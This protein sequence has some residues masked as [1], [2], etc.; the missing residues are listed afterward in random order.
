MTSPPIRRA[1]EE[2]HLASTFPG[3]LELP[4]RRPGLRRRRL[5]RRRQQRRRQR[6]L[7]LRQRR[8]NLTIYSS[9]PLQ[10][11]SRPQSEA[12]VNGEKLALEAGRRQ[13]RRLHDQVRV[14]RRRHGCGRQVGRRRRL[15]QRAQG[16]AGQ[17]DDRLPRRVQL[18]R[19]GDLDPDPNE[20]GILQVSPVEHRA[21]PDQERRGRRQG[22]AGQVLPDA[23]SAPT[24]ASSRSTTS[25]APPRRS[26]EGRGLHEASTS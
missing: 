8:K 17:V 20:A 18:R 2:G 4:D 13:G 10:G 26:T 3:S 15:G 5:R 22:R 21:R 24:A 19:L 14:A 7:R 12:V 11:D 1:S 9:L 16:R 25:R 23:A 6:Q